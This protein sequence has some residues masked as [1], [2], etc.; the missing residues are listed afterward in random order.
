MED[1]REARETV[2]PPLGIQEAERI[3]ARLEEVVSQRH[4]ILV[5]GQAVAL[6]T[7]YLEAHFDGHVTIAQV[8][9]SDLD[10]LAYAEDAR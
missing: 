8:V 6:W 9:S 3:I 7:A 1:Q 4:A 10:L 2:L 5:G